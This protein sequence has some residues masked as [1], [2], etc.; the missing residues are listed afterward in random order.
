MK[1]TQVFF[2]DIER[3]FLINGS[4]N[5]SVNMVSKLRNV[6][7]VSNVTGTDVARFTHKSVPVIFEPPCTFR[8]LETILTEVLYYQDLVSSWDEDFFLLLLEFTFLLVYWIP[9]P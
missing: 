2:P 7:S 5:T 4:N 9:G 6:Q 3:M 8:S 1:N